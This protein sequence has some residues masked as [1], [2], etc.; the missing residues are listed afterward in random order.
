[1]ATD[2]VGLG[3]DWTRLS[4]PGL[5]EPADYIVTCINLRGLLQ[6]LI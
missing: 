5:S 6:A 3:I 1:M 2:R 4:A